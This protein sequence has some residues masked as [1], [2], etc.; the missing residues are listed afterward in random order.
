M[1][2]SDEIIR[3]INNECHAY[4]SDHDTIIVKGDLEIPKEENFLAEFLLYRYSS[5]QNGLDV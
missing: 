4:I 3:D 5:I 2:T 1:F